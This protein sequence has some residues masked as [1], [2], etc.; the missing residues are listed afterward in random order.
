M[1]EE[2]ELAGPPYIF[3]YRPNNDFT[4]DE[5]EDNYIYFS[6]IDSLNDPFD[7]NPKLIRL[8]ENKEEWENFHRLMSNNIKEEL[9]QSYFQR[10][11]TSENLEKFVQENIERFI[12]RFGI[13]CFSINP[14]NLPLWG[15]YA[16]NYKGVCLQFNADLDTDFFSGLRIVQYE[17]NLTQ[18]E[19]KPFSNENDII[20][21]FYR[22]Q[23]NWHYEFE[24]RL[25]KNFQ[26]KAQFKKE[27]LR[28]VI[29]GYN[30][31]IEYI[32]KASGIIKQNYPHAKAYQLKKPTEINTFSFVEI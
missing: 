26:G 12:K 30:T 4:L 6:D 2:I 10:N 27:A 3:R 20:D 18:K 24:V 11:F 31:D 1:K 23:E 9:T 17:N 22:K 25:I 32:E 13:A 21:L 28:N 5:L 8:T 16:G 7:S 14:I 29:F 15:N 19:F